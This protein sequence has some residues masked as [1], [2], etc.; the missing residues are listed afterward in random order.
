[1]AREHDPQPLASHGPHAGNHCGSA[2]RYRSFV[3]RPREHVPSS[4]GAAPQGAR[5]A[6]IAWAWLGLLFC[7]GFAL[8]AAPPLPGFSSAVHFSRRIWQSSDGLPEDFAQALA[9]TPDGYLWIGTSG[10]LVRF[11]GI[12]FTVFS[13][14]TDP[15]FHDDSVY[16]LLVARDGT[17][18]AGT[19][20]GGL[21]RYRDGA[22]RS[23][24]PHEGLANGF[25]RVI[26]EDRSGVLWAGTDDG[27]YR[28]Q[29]ESL[30]R[31]DGRNGIPP[32]AVHSICQDRQGRLL[33]GGYGLLVLDGSTAAYYTSS[34]TLADNSIRTIH[35]TVD[36]TLWI[37]TI[38]G[39]RRLGRGL[40]GNPFL[41]P[42]IIR[43]T[44]VDFLMQ[45]RS[46]P[47]WIGTYGQGVLRYWEG[48][49]ERFSAPALLPH[50]NV[51]SI[52]E[53]IENDIWIGTQGGLLRLSPS[54]AITLTTADG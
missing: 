33:F 12:R 13:S 30:V 41:A 52:F 25:V 28:L 27:L 21:I 35:Q 15:A 10:G 51:L 9:Q 22:F 50:N 36:G 11:D 19:E 48:R 53:D 2:T 14:Q 40:D 45:S 5:R 23:Y 49:F 20:G 18:W 24:G 4:V 6:V 47:L 31:V 39:L 7:W 38:S 32:I 16:S 42:K 1:M 37:G 43:N 3:A 54:A 34:E 29:G 8:S 26:F 44:N 17:L 46:G